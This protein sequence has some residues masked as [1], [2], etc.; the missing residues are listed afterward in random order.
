MAGAGG[1][2]TAAAG[3]GGGGGVAAGRSGGGGGGGAAA[4][5]GAG[6]PDPR[7]EA[8]RCPRRGT[9]AR[10]ASATGRAAARC[11]TSPSAAGA[12]RTS[13]RGA[14]ARRLVAAWGGAGL[15]AGRPAAVS[16]AGGGAAG[17]SPASSLAL[18]QPGSL[19]SLSSALGLTGGTSLASLLLGSGGSGGD[20]LGL[21]QAMQSVVSDAAAF[22]MHQQHQSQVDHL[23][24]LG[25]GAA[26]AQIQAAKPWLHDG[27]AT[28][29]LLDG[30][31]A[32]LLSGSIVPG[33]EELQ[34]KA[35]ATT[36][37]HPQNSSAAAAR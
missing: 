4:A 28:G 9:S 14:A 6:A 26:G 37:D 21:F 34:V 32:P 12:G 35:E 23:L 30:F 7:A 33:L 17:T 3:G 24:G 19:P 36:G 27:G 25:Y 11:G 16:S 10:R 29:G 8:L 5:A 20:H 2:A 22:E 13:G 1:A 31:Y 15:E 18:P